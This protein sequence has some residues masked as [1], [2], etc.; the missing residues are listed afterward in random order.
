MRAFFFAEENRYK[1]DEIVLRQLRVLREH[2]GP[3]EE[4]LGLFDAK[5]MFFQMRNRILK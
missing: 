3:R 1:Q 5:A 4:T 2:Q